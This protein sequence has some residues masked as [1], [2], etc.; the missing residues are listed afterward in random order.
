MVSARE[1]WT[2][3]HVTVLG[4]AATE[5]RGFV[6]LEVRLDELRAVPGFVSLPTESASTTA[7]LLLRVETAIPLGLRPGERLEARVRRG[8]DARVLFADE[9]TLRR[10]EAPP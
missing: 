5:R 7:V 3:V 8:R 9:R 6:A 4:D 2:D 1:N 10:L